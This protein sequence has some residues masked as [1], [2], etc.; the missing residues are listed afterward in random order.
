MGR[1]PAAAG[2]FMASLGKSLSNFP[3]PR[4]WLLSSVSKTHD[5]NPTQLIETKEQRERP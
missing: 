2:Q 4:D 3:F 1:Q 5:R